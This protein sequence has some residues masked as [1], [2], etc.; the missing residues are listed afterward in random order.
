MSQL[1]IHMQGPQ[2]VIV[3]LGMM[4]GAPL[5]VQLVDPTPEERDRRFITIKKLLER[6]VKVAYH[7]N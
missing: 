2:P 3:Y 7:A 6:D 1:P 4:A 5:Y